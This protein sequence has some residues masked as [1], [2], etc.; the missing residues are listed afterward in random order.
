[1]AEK[2]LKNAW[3]MMGWAH[4]LDQGPVAR[5]IA[6]LP[7]VAFRTESG[8]LAC[9][10]D[11][12]PHR[13]APL[14]RGKVKGEGLQCGYH[15]LVFDASG[16]CTHNP[17]GGPI[18]AAAKVRSFPVV[19]RNRI[20]WVWLGDP[21][22]ARPETIP[23]M[24]C[25]DWPGMRF[26]FGYTHNPAHYETI[27]DNLLDLTH[28]VFLHP[29]FGGEGYVPSFRMDIQGHTVTSLYDYTGV[30]NSDFY[31]SLGASYTGPTD[32]WD[33]M[34][35]DPP[36]T[37][38]LESGITGHQRPRS[39]GITLPAVHIL[40]PETAQST[41]YWWAS[42]VALDSPC[43][44]E[45]LRAVLSQAFDVEDKPMIQAVNERMQGRS[46]WDMKP[47]LLSTDGAAVRARRILKSLIDSE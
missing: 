46:F 45:A 40:A 10:E 17:L 26:V 11:M 22:L 1:M 41:H 6:D 30:D 20:L 32:Q 5:I 12:C 34:R 9:L 14:S 28:A 13:F 42:G 33:D 24:P 3:T 27:T 7:L 44:D 8:E 39:E 4:E 23:H 37:M 2:F 16:R 43:S 38:Y 15:G 25:F 31:R 35:W 18:P 21:A 29:G 47:V 36:C 19:A